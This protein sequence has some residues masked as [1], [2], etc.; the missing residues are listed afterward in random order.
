MHDHVSSLEQRLTRLEHRVASL[1][2]RPVPPPVDAEE[3]PPPWM[4]PEPLVAPAAPAAGGTRGPAGFDEDEVLR[5]WFPR[6]GALALVLGAA[7]GFKYAVDQGFIGPAARVLSGLAAG[8][9]LLV[10]GEG[11]RRR[12]WNA[13]AQAVSGGGIALLYLSTWAGHHLYGYLSSQAAC[14]ALLV[15]GALGVLVALRHDAEPLAVIAGL[16]AFSS[17]FAA[18]ATAGLGGFMYVYVLAV[19]AAIVGLAYLR[20]WRVVSKVAFS[21]TWLIFHAAAGPDAPWVVAATI[22]FVLF[23]SAPRVRA[24]L[25]SERP[26]AYDAVF[27]VANG[28]VY[29]TAMVARLSD[30]VRQPA[31]PLALVMAAVYLA[32]ASPWRLRQPAGDPLSRAATGLSLFFVTIWSPLELG[33]SWTPIA[34]ALESSALIL[35]SRQWRLPGTRMAALIVLG[36]AVWVH[37]ATGGLWETLLDGRERWTFGIEVAALYLLAAVSPR[38]ASADPLRAVGLVGANALTILWVSLEVHALL[39][40]GSGETFPRVQFALSAVWAT[41]AGVLLAVGVAARSRTLRVMSVALFALTLTKMTFTD[42]WLLPTLHRLMGFVGV[43]M[44]LLA[45]SL[46]YQRFRAFLLESGVAQVRPAARQ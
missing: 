36:A 21:V 34:W 43:G 33:L 42:L 2:R 18:G 9:L 44:L 5:T 39:G 12:A 13:F 8:I 1:E 38:G 6:V 28:V 24:L 30:G 7:F 14:A 17:P 23:G 46:M 19:D 20:P 10:I 40:R 3:A 32:A 22:A 41:Y 31:A 35:A 26:T 45:C 11:T 37:L 27:F 25:R 15:V 29:Y 4:P 16:A